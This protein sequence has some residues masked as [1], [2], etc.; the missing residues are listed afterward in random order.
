M[1]AAWYK[2][3][4]SSPS[5]DQKRERNRELESHKSTLD[6]IYNILKDRLDYTIPSSD[7][8]D[9]AWAYKQ[10]DRNGYNRAIKEVLDLVNIENN[11]E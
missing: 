7:Y 2:D 6:R 5:A 9:T 11:R 1:K 3:L 10:A 8:E 4:G